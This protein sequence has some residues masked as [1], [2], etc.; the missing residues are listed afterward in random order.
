MTGVYFKISGAWTQVDRPYVK[1]SGAWKPAKEVWVKR[2][3]AWV[4][5]YL[6]D[7]TPPDPP[8][9]SLEIVV[10]SSG[11]RHIK[12]GARS[13]GSSH[14][15]NLKR[16]RVLTTYNGKAP[17]TQ[18]GG[19]YTR[20][21]DD[22]FPDEPWSDWSYN[23]FNSSPSGKDSSEYHYKTWPRSATPETTL[24]GGQTYYFTAWA[25]D[26]AGNWSVAQAALINVPKSGGDSN[27]VVKEARFQVNTSGKLV[28]S[29]FAS[30]DL[31]QSGGP[32]SRGIWLY[33]TE[34]RNNIG[35]QG[36]ATIRSA[37]IRI[38]RR[39][40]TGQPTANL[41]L[42]WHDYAGAGSLPSSPTRH[43]ATKIGQIAKGETKW[44]DLPSAFYSH[45]TG[46]DILG[47]GLDNKN[48]SFAAAQPSDYS[49]VQSVSDDI[50][51]GEV[52][53]VWSE[54]LT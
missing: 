12:V 20:A 31:I 1:V 22:N 25:E 52:H 15:P 19:T 37:Q 2:S 44:F 17:T 23:G 6:F 5:S 40:D 30:G 39:D 14:D 29:G 4:Q 26:V 54:D 34:I 7:I 50:R 48:P 43:Q 9:L 42:Y 45:L 36:P 16:I 24:A 35:S 28:S 49:E 41:Y 27:T 10:T 51:T 47:F 21:A 18:F 38:S 8:T 13:P 3:G 53:V 32:A 11:G 33:G 46:K